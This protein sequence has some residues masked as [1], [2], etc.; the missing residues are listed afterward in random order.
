MSSGSLAG[1]PV[2]DVTTT[3]YDGSYH[4]VDS[5]VLAFQ[6]RRGPALVVPA[7]RQPR[8]AAARRRPCSRACAGPAGACRLACARVCPPRPAVLRR[9]TPA[10]DRLRRARRSARA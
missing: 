7:G 3:L 5:S 6:V 10:P 8:L 1:F 9:H 2:V 4:D